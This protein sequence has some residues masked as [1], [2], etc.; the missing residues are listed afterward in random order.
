MQL[1]S[2]CVCSF[3]LWPAEEDPTDDN[4]IVF[5]IDVRHDCGTHKKRSK[6][7]KDPG[8]GDQKTMVGVWST[9]VKRI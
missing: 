2:H 9:R 1:Y 3:P 4:T 7:D 6:K 8:A 5:K